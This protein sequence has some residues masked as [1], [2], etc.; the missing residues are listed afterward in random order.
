[1]VTGLITIYKGAISMKKINKNELLNCISDGMTI[2]IGGFMTVGAP[3][4]LIQIIAES[5]VKNLTIICNDT[6]VNRDGNESS[7]G[8]GHLLKNGCVN[9]VIASHIGLNPDTGKQM[10]AGEVEVELSPQG[11]LIERIHAGGAGL[12]GV[13]TPTGL[14][15]V[16]SENKTII[17]VN[18]KK[19]LLESPLKADVALL[20]AYK[21]DEMGNLVYH[22]TARNFNPEMAFAARTV[23]A[24]VNEIVNVGELNPEEIITPF[25]LVDK[26][27]EK[28]VD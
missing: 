5:G 14:G 26:L 21:A 19:Y 6:G 24:E 3:T 9:K 18:N 11:T 15:T 1:M 2:M 7:L 10:I 25:I 4:E 23:I 20:K 28:K 27:F 17:N 12:G 22:Q 13:L 8:V 16:V